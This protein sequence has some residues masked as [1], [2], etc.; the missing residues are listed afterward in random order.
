[1]MAINKSILCFWHQ[2]NFSLSF[3]KIVKALINKGH[4]QIHGSLK[5]SVHVQKFF[6]RPGKKRNR[7]NEKIDVDPNEQ[8]DHDVVSNSFKTILLYRSEV[9]K[10]RSYLYIILLITKIVINFFIL[11]G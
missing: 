6:P 2:F 8:V 10:P 9:Y 3:R 7:L 5:P 4:H 11:L 1:M